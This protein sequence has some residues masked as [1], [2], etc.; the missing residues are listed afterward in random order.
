MVG[1]LARV[2]ERVE[3]IDPGSKQAH[4]RAEAS[5]ALVIKRVEQVLF[6]G[7][8]SAVQGDEQFGALLGGDHA[9]S[10]TVGRVGAALDESGR[11]E[12]VQQIGHDRAVDAEVL[13]EGELAPNH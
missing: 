1:K 3:S 8:Q 4:L 5:A 12:I 10:A 7:A 6:G 2:G 11:F 9:T 13:G